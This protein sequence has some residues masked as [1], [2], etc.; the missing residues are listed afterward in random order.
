MNNVEIIE[1]KKPKLN[2]PILIQGLVGIGNV[3]RIAVDYLIEELKAEKFA[4]LLSVHFMHF[5]LVDNNSVAST[6]KNEFYFWKAKKPNQNDLILLIGDAQ[7]NSTQ[8]HYEIARE[9][10][11]F[12]LKY[13]VK[14]IITIGGLSVGEAVEEPKVV[15]VANDLDLIRKYSKYNIDFSGTEVGSIVGTNGLVVGIAKYYNIK[16][17]CLLGQTIG[18]PV[19]PDPKSAKAVL[20]VLSK[21]LNLK[22]S[23]ERID[24]KIAE[25][26]RFLKRMEEIQRKAFQQMFKPATEEKERLRYIG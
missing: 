19:I 11:K 22:I 16:A 23:L 4:E 2:N 8:G 18:Y 21:M 24:K 20:E 26:D 25:M 14:E 12:A 5:V 15:G 7:S 13:K 9:I 3:G 6:L 17:I 1:F 10:V